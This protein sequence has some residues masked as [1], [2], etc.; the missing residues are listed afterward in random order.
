MPRLYPIDIII[1]TERKFN[2]S[3][4]PDDPKLEKAPSAIR[5]MKYCEKINRIESQEKE[6]EAEQCSRELE[7]DEEVDLGV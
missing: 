5:Q 3:R 1:D 4:R 6:A 2:G 7:D